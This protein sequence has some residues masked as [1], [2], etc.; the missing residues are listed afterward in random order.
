MN[1]RRIDILKDDLLNGDKPNSIPR[2]FLPINEFY[3]T[4]SWVAQETTE[5]SQMRTDPTGL[6][7]DCIWKKHKNVVKS[8]IKSL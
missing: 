4:R 3:Q 6:V 1:L 7:L 8:K 5:F 2:S